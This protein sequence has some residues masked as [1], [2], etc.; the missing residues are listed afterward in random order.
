MFL[1]PTGACRPGQAERSVPSPWP[2]PTL[3]FILEQSML[4]AWVPPGASHT[5]VS[6]GLPCVSRWAGH[7]P[8]IA[9]VVPAPAARDSAASRGRE[10]GF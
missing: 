10:P 8:D 3:V 1:A 4:K 7:K 5:V 2:H 9:H 6:C